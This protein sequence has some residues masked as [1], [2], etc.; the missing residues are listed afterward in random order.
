MSNVSWASYQE[1]Y[2]KESMK[3]VSEKVARVKSFDNNRANA[4]SSSV[5]NIL[6]GKYYEKGDQWDVAAWRIDSAMMRMISDP[7]KLQHKAGMMGIFH[8]EVTDVKRGANPTAVIRVTQIEKSGIKIV[9][10]KVEYL[11]LTMDDTMVQ[12]KKAYHLQNAQRSSNVSPEG[13]H[14]NIT[15]LELFPLDVPEL[16]TALRKSA[17]AIPE[18]PED[19][20]AQA[21]QLGFKPDLSQSLWLEQDDFF[22]RPIDVLWQHG[23]PWPSYFKTSNGIAILL[24]KGN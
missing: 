22:G 9:D 17:Q 18:L 24:K 2:Y 16:N 14:S 11:T 3:A 19:I 7:D 6:Y 8:Y 15:T 23:N 20:R 13:L 1:D 4:I 5:L 12:S 21:L 10:P